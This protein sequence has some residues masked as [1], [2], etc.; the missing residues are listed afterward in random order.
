M[1][2][3]S[4]SE[5]EKLGE[6]LALKVKNGG[7]TALYGELGSGKTTFVKGLARGLG[8]KKRIVSPTFIF[9]RQYEILR[10]EKARTKETH[11]ECAEHSPGVGELASARFFYHIDLY[12]INKA[13]DARGL[14]LEEILS[15]SKNIVVIEWAARIKK[16]LPKKR[17]DIHFKYLDENKREVLIKSS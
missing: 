8:I 6:N 13:E 7:L 17:I 2:T 4:A 9:I 12:R 15:D 1:I 3:N 14:G 11:R 5:T 10:S 16:L